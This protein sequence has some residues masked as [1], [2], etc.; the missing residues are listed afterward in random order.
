MRTLHLLL[1]PTFA[2]LAINQATQATQQ[3]GTELS[4]GEKLVRQLRVN[5]WGVSQLRGSMFS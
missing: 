3:S 2:L 4:L 5:V 1:I